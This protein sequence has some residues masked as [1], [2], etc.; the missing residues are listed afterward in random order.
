MVRADPDFDIF[1]EASAAREVLALI[2]NKW[3]AMIVLRLAEAPKRYSQLGREVG[4]ISQKML[5]QTLRQLERNG[6]VG[7]RSYPVLPP[8]VE[9]T[10]TPL[11]RTLLGPLTAVLAWTGDHLHELREARE[12][13]DANLALD[14]GEPSPTTERP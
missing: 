11:G 9:Y 12:R 13:Y 8:K 14:D 5:T 4:G 1:D 6:V 2:A 3:S 10:L 7:R